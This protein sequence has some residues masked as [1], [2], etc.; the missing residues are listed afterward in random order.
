[1]QAIYEFQTEVVVIAD[2]GMGLQ[3]LKEDVNHLR[4]TLHPNTSQFNVGVTQP[5][6]QHTVQ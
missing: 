3:R 5:I 6:S 2:E 1:M 4:G